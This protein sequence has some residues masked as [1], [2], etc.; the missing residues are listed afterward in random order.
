M[1]IMCILLYY[2]KLFV[3]WLSH[4]IFLYFVADD[5]S[6]SYDDVVV[7]RQFSINQAGVGQ[8]FNL[9]SLVQCF[10]FQLL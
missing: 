4:F 10:S 3:F 8:K 2:C 9:N 7:I 6:E 1:Y 5:I